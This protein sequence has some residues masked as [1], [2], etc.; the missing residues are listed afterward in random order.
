MKKVAVVILNWNG[1]NWL[2]KF[3][4]SVVKYSSDKAEIIIADNASTDDSVAFVRE[5]SHAPAPHT[6]CVREDPTLKKPFHE[7][8]HA[9]SIDKSVEGAKLFHRVKIIQHPVN[10]GF[11]KGYNE[12][13]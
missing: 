7:V 11:T 2:E 6:I 9:E 12:A 8:H 1:R 3:L 5:H 13:L 4:P 10:L